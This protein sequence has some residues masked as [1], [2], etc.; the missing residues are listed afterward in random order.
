MSKKNIQKVKD[1]PR[2]FALSLKKTA[3]NNAAEQNISVRIDPEKTTESDAR[4]GDNKN[5]GIPAPIKNANTIEM[6]MPKKME[7][8]ILLRLMGWANIRVINSME[9]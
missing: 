6:L 4:F 9:L 1:T 7:K 2:P 8:K 5:T 3:N